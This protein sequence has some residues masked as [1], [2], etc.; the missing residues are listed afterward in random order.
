MH[1]CIKFYVVYLCMV[2]SV[3]GVVLIFYLNELLLCISFF[4]LS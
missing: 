4:V 1:E 2:P 3:F